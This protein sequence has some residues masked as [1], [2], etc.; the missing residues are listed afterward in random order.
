MALPKPSGPNVVGFVDYQFTPSTEP[1][2]SKPASLGTYPILARI[3]YPSV[4]T[5]SRDEDWD[6]ASYWIPSDDYHFCNLP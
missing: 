6:G 3:W 1:V 5:T 4:K 2:L